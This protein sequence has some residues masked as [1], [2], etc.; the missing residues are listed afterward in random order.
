MNSTTPVETPSVLKHHEYEP[1]LG[2]RWL[3]FLKKV[4]ANPE[5]RH[6]S[7]D[8]YAG[9]SA[10]TPPFRHA[11]PALSRI[12]RFQDRSLPIH[13]SSPIILAA[14]ANKYA[15]HLADFASLGF[16]G[17]TVGSAT[18][19]ARD[20]NPYRPRIRLLEGE[21]GMQNAMGL[22]NP[23]IEVIAREVDKGLEACHRRGMAVGISIA[24]TPGL[25]DEDEIIAETLAVFRKAYAAADY[26]ELNLSCPNTGADRLDSDPSF[27]ATLLREIMDTRKSLAPRKAVLVKLSPDMNARALDNTL[28]IVADTGITGVV[29]FNT[30]PAEKSRYLKLRA[31]ETFLLPVTGEGRLGGLSGRPLYQNTLPA[32]RHIRRALPK[33]AIFA[34]GGVDHGAK[35]LDLLAAGADAVQAY[36]V[37][38]YRWNA[39]WKMQD[40]LLTAMR[41][42]GVTS[43]N[44]PD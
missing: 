15:R 8:F 38:A 39:A 43:L 24:D 17:I 16:G 5:T 30:F 2:D 7:L 6:K 41:A 44:E 12:I 21:R 22:N 36:T 10:K 19:A 37:L 1:T 23:G 14:G 40:E 27:L 33:T 29:L 34:A 13:L 31:P 35:V 42:R 9:L 28:R 20:G 4:V 3:A 32:V 26:L 25:T 11:D 18:L